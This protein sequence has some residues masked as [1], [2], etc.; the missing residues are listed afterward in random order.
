MNFIT[1]LFTITSLLSQDWN[2]SA[3]ILEKKIE[4]NL[5][6]RIFKSK[7]QTS[8]NVIISRDTISIF[9]NLFILLPPDKFILR[10]F[11]N[12]SFISAYVGLVVI[13]LS[14]FLT[15]TVVRVI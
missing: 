14:K 13:V 1:I 9:T 6:V 7:N 8:Q 2:Y 11:L 12:D 15:L 4:N 5:E 10:Q 3:D